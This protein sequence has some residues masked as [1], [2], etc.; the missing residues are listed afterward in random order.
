MFCVGSRRAAMARSRKRPALIPCGKFGRKRVPFRVSCCVLYRRRKNPYDSK[1]IC[2]HIRVKY[3]SIPYNNIIVLFNRHH[4]NTT[5]VLLV[6]SFL[7]AST[8]PAF[9]Y[10]YSRDQG[11]RCAAADTGCATATVSFVTHLLLAPSIVN[12]IRQSLVTR[13]FQQRNG[14]SFLKPQFQTHY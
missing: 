5:W 13:S 4:A 8:Q 2:I 12:S 9:Q 1:Y 11:W 6:S 10:L 3:Y 14:S 7:P